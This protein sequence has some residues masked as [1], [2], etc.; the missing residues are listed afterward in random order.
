MHPARRYRLHITHH[1][2]EAGCRAQADEQMHMVGDATDSFRHA[3]DIPHHAAEVGVQSFPPCGGDDRSTILGAKDDVV[4]E[5]EMCGWHGVRGSSAPAG[6]RGFLSAIRWLT[7]PA[8]FD[9]ALRA[10]AHC[11]RVPS[12][13]RR[14]LRRAFPA[15]LDQLPKPAFLRAWCAV[16]Y[17]FPGLHPDGYEDA[18]SGWPRVLKRFAAEAWRRADAGEL[19]DEELHP[20]DAQWGG[21]LRPDAHPRGQRNRP[22]FPNRRRPRR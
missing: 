22:P 3:F 4:M 21:A 1:V 16:A 13:L 17:A 6:A 9:A 12:N 5:R 19:A 18:G 20:C 10:S 7:P 14:E 8:N 11:A 2:C 15:Q